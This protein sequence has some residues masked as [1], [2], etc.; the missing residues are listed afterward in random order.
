MT[1]TQVTLCMGG[2][3]IA[4]S[5]SLVLSKSAAIGDQCLMCNQFAIIRR[6]GFGTILVD[7]GYHHRYHF[8]STE[9]FPARIY[10]EV[11]INVKIQYLKIHPEFTAR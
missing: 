11:N 9:A 10:R 6:P 1:Q 3:C 8:E 4:I 2:K 7:T 5:K